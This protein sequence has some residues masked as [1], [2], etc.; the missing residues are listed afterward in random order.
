MSQRTQRGLGPRR[1]T[2]DSA[3]GGR[4]GILSVLPLP[5]FGSRTVEIRCGFQ[6]T[7]EAYG[8]GSA[9]SK[10]IEAK[11]MQNHE[12]Q[13]SETAG[14]SDAAAPRWRHRTGPPAA[15]ADSCL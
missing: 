7:L 14:R 4:G 6:R 12:E 8:G 2:A 3:C 9:V 10:Y 11:E 5:R 1:E 13:D 15:S